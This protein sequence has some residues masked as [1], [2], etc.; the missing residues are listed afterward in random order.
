MAQQ[1]HLTS[2]GHSPAA[3]RVWRC[4]RGGEACA[5]CS[6]AVRQM[7]SQ[8]ALETFREVMQVGSLLADTHRQTLYLH[9]LD[10]LA[11][12]E[13]QPCAGSTHV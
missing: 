8:A 11:S 9:A 6:L 4:A 13:A 10:L 7:Y 12:G 3:E 2:G 5:M 1:L